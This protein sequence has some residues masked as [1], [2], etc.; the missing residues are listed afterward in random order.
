MAVPVGVR[1]A[2]VLLWAMWIRIAVYDEVSELC[3]THTT[4]TTTT[5]TITITTTTHTT[6]TIT[7]TI[8]TSNTTLQTGQRAAVAVWCAP[9]G[10]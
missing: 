3:A 6:H 4:T 10:E 8:P 1:A 2:I 7:T 5:I 9:E